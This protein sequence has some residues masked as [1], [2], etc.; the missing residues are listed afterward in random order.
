MKFLS[1]SA[2]IG[3]PA[4]EIFRPWRSL[5][6][7]IMLLVAATVGALYVEVAQAQGVDGAITGLT[8]SSE[9]PGTLT[10][11]WDAASPTPTDYR[12]DWAKST[13]EYKSWTVDD[14]HVYPAETATAA[15]IADLS[16]DTQYKVR[17]RARYYTGEHKG[18]SWG[19]P[20]ATATIIV[21][22][23]PAETPTPD[24]TPEPS[25][26]P[27]PDPTPEPGTITGL[28]L[29]S[30]APGTLT[31]SWETASPT[32][33]DYRIDWAT[34]DEDYTIMEGRRRTRLSGSNRHGRDHH[35]PQTT[36]PST[37]SACVL[38]TTQ[39]NTSDNSW[40]GPWATAT[41][42]VA[43][44]PAETPTPEPGTIDTLAA[45]DD[46][47]GQLVLTWGPPAAPNA[48][49]T[50][51]HINWAKSTASYPADTAEAGNTHPTAPP[52][53]WR[54]SSTTL[55]TTSGYEHATRTARTPTARGTDRG[56][57]Q[58]PRSS[59]RCPW[60]STSWEPPSVR[61]IKFFCFGRTPR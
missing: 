58:P 6:L 59:C 20:W 50:D 49:P 40:G 54:A 33:T 31:V 11:S 24:P 39:V 29:T 38:A 60:P 61:K 7:A 8:L 21:A 15:T 5:F 16:H 18:N 10:V 25:P 53:R 46:D 36:T 45:T 2:I 27:T 57:R 55:T 13:E 41:I 37:R 52:I 56:P 19:G 17:L 1:A 3:R 26:D 22:G 34:S 32:P 30:D 48:A 4:L 23:E 51:Y 28:T 35:G 14:G 42:I 12:I 44:E 47:T 43:G 9:A